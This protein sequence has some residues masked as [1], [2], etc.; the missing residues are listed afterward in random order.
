M[1]EFSYCPVVKGKLND[2]KAASLVRGLATQAITPLY[3]LPPFLPTDKP[4]QILNRFATRLA[5]LPRAGCYIDFPLLKPGAKTSS[6][7]LALQFAF[8]CLNACGIPFR[9]VYGFDRDDAMWPLVVRQ[10]NYSGGLLLRLEL[11]DVEYGDETIDR[12]ID[13][14]HLGIDRRNVDLMI[15]CRYL[16]NNDFALSAAAQVGDFIEKLASAVSIGRTIVAGSCAPKT[17]SNIAK[18]SMDSI[19]R[20]ELTLWANVASNNPSRDIIYSDYGVVHP[21]FSDLVPSKN[22]N[23][24]I[25]YTEGAS[26]HIFRGHSLFEGDKFEQYREL[27][28]AVM[29]SPYYQGREFSYGDQYI[30]DCAA[31]VVGTGNA[32]TWVLVDQNHH[33]TYAAR[34]VHRLQSLI[35][36]GLSAESVLAMA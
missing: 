26:I 20:T 27:S 8:E 24:K 31:R 1:N 14:A 33:I 10:A 30:S 32:G 15:D 13:L 5:N 2:I 16:L 17:V 3:E 12:I 23:G 25:R 9:P 19:S 4:E 11:D 36:R 21:D 34:Q 28:A 6:G 29:R 35:K 7:Q 22:I 18:N